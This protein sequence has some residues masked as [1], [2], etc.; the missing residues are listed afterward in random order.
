MNVVEVG[1]FLRITLRENG[2]NTPGCNV[3]AGPF[4]G[5]YK[6]YSEANSQ[7]MYA[8]CLERFRGNL[9]SQEC[10][11]IA[12]DPPVHEWL[13]TV[14]IKWYSAPPHL[15]FGIPVPQKTQFCP[16]YCSL[17]LKLISFI[18]PAPRIVWKVWWEPAQVMKVIFSLAV[19]QSSPNDSL[20]NSW[21]R[22]VF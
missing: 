18:Q 16:S 17:K 2:W 7:K 15:L 13:K 14:T 6:T 11:S 4:N 5:M 21:L 8:F 20:T 3:S 22:L 12:A 19:D 9:K 1:P 10:G